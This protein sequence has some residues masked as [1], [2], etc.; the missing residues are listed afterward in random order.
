[1][2]EG[3]AEQF[4]A[5]VVPA[6]GM[7]CW[8]WRPTAKSGQYGMFEVSGRLMAAHRWCYEYLIGPIPT[9][10]VADH[11]CMNKPCVNPWHLDP[12]TQQVNTQR[13]VLTPSKAAA[14]TADLRRRILAGEFAGGL[15]LQRDLQRQYG[16]SF[17]V[18][19][20][21]LARLGREGLVTRSGNRGS[22][23]LAA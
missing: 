19:G 13:G 18:L 1:M 3:I 8:V 6:D 2:T 4:F 21:A 10:L 5:N 15:P 7:A 9:G 23:R 17:H 20:S 16:S 22:W 14:V 12:V 11:L